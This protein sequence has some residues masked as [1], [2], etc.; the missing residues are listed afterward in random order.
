MDAPTLAITAH[1]FFFVAHS[2][3]PG[4]SLGRGGLPLRGCRVRVRV[5]VRQIDLREQINLPCLCHVCCESVRRAQELWEREEMGMQALSS[6]HEACSIMLARAGGRSLVRTGELA[7]LAAMS[8]HRYK[9]GPCQCHGGVLGPWRAAPTIEIS[10][11]IFSKLGSVLRACRLDAQTPM[12]S[13]MI[14][15]AAAPSVIRISN[16]RT[17]RSC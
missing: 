13:P 12:V 5:K 11:L 1:P 2:G 6:A 7:R 15:R 17:Q 3:D 9:N 4:K 8:V 16:V 14:P 10:P